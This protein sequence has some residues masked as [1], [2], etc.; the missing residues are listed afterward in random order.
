MRSPLIQILDTMVKLDAHDTRKV[1]DMADLHL[2]DLEGVRDKSQDRCEVCFVLRS[3]HHGENF[4]GY[5]R[6]S[7]RSPP[8]QVTAPPESTC[9][10]CGGDW[11]DAKHTGGLC[12]NP[13][14]EGAELQRGLEAA[15]V[16]ERERLDGPDDE[17][18]AGQR[19]C[20]NPNA[21]VC[22]TCKRGG[23]RGHVGQ[24]GNF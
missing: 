2:R 19:G 15:V 23:E 8:Q 20:C 3:D 11:A 18:P 10:R 7:F 13:V 9:L 21:V 14:M 1:R 24:T 5:V 6:H 17:E 16:R 22:P 12:Q 4:G